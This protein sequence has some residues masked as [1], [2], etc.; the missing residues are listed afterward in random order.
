[1]RAEKRE[2][3]EIAEAIDWCSEVF[4]K[5]RD[6]LSWSVGRGYACV[7]E[8]RQR[9]LEVGSAV[10][11]PLNKCNCMPE[12]FGCSGD[13]FVMNAQDCKRT[14]RVARAVRLRSQSRTHW[15]FKLRFAKTI[16]MLGSTK[17]LPRELWI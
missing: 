8:G 16:P 6:S 3:R 5:F 9:A 15:Q 11:L 10:I 17:Q 13:V 1:M 12:P 14:P 4:E 2:L 7:A